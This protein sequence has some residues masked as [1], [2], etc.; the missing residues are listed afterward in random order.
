MQRVPLD[1][2]EA[3][4]LLR[5]HHLAGRTVAGGDLGSWSD[6]RAPGLPLMLSLPMRVFREQISVA[7]GIKAL[8]GAASIVA[9]AWRVA[10][11]ARFRA[12]KV[13]PWLVV[14]T[15]IF[16]FYVDLVRLDVPGT[17]VVVL[18]ALAF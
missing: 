9:T 18:A 2:D 17:L 3:V 4:Y 10:R 13:A 11:I 15:G 7:R 16:K 6:Y 12:G 14:I 5:A 1:R 8:I